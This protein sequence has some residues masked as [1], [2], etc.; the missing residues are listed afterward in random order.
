LQGKQL[1]AQTF[2][3]A[4]IEASYVRNEHTAA[5]DMKN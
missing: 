5:I 1:S 3:D 2:I 4:M